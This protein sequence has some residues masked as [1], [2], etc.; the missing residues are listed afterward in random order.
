MLL[1]ASCSRTLRGPY[2]GLAGPGVV[3]QQVGGQGGG[4]GLGQATAVQR[5]LAAGVA[6]PRA[7]VMPVQPQQLLPGEE[8][9]P[10][11]ERHRPLGQ[12]LGQAVGGL[13][14][15]IL[16]DVGGV[17]AALQPAVQAQGDHAAQPLAVPF[18]QR[19]PALRVPP[20]RSL[21]QPVRF[22]RVSRRR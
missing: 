2:G 7:Q 12:V 19:P 5:H 10:E 18:Q 16:D 13:Q 14:V 15:G 20:G 22:V 6:H 9:Q 17:D 21:E 11:E 4:R 3:P 1:R 8:A